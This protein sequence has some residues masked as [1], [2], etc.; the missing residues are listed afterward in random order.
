M[1]GSGPLVTYSVEIEGGLP[2]DLP[3]VTRFV[4]AVLA[5]PDGWTAAGTAA[6]QRVSVHPDIRILL[7]SPEVTDELCRPLD[8]GGRLSCRNG[9]LVVL[10]AWRW[11][12]GARTY[13]DSLGR[14]RRYMVNHE[15]GHA[16]G[17]AHAAC[18]GPG[19]LAPVMVQQTMGLDGCLSNPW[20]S[21]AH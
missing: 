20:P 11:V 1:A 5:H 17:N 13:A 19:E 4:D 3:Q 14:Y 8:T 9:E 15:F 12:N 2:V 21:A 10:N 6:L 16:L 18:P 7:A